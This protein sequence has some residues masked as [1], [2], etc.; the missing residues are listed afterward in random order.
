M[1]WSSV[2]F[3]ALA[4][5]ITR[6][7]TAG[8]ISLSRTG[9]APSPLRLRMWLL[10]MLTLTLRMLQSAMLSASDTARWIDS[11]V[12]SM[13]TTLPAFRPCERA[14]PN[15][16]SVSS[17]SSSRRA[18]STAI[19]DVPMSIATVCSG[20]GLPRPKRADSRPQRPDSSGSRGR[21]AAC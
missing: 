16:S 1:R 19:L 18:T 6:S 11:T 8:V 4:A 3:T 21:A 9:I 5:S 15:P 7:T 2:S 17:P 12:C 10:A 13:L 14:E 20:S